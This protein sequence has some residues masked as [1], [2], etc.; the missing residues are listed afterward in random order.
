M[1]YD[2]HMV[3]KLHSWEQLMVGWNL[4]LGRWICILLPPP[5]HNKDI[6]FNSSYWL[7]LCSQNNPSKASFSICIM[8]RVWGFWIHSIPP[9]CST[10]VI[11]ECIC[12]LRVFSRFMIPRSVMVLLLAI[13]QSV[14]KGSGV[15]IV[16][17]Y[18]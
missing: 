1:E 7:L 15:Q 18:A 17:K 5:K 16:V 9:L 12:S 3:C 8:R 14:N 13:E 10:H 11:L 4:L 2:N 6:L